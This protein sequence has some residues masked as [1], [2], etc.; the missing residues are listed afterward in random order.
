[1]NEIQVFK[2]PQG[3]TRLPDTDL[4]INR[5]Q[6]KSESSNRLYTIALNTS[7]NKW[8]CSC[9]AWRT[10]RYCKHLS[11]LNLPTLPPINPRAMK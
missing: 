1:M 5:F 8:G 10:R 2:P 9:P 4:W 7:T 3:C 11:S 6:I